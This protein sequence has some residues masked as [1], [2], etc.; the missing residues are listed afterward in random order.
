MFA[1]SWTSG[2]FCFISPWYLNA[3]GSYVGYR[4]LRTYK[5]TRFGR[6]ADTFHKGYASD[7]FVSPLRFPNEAILWC[8]VVVSLPDV[9]DLCRAEPR[10]YTLSL[11]RIKSFVFA[12]LASPRREFSARLDSTW[13]R[14]TN[15]YYQLSSPPE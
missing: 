2:N 11:R 6:Y 12:R 4:T 9:I 10:W 1:S 14:V 13:L 8:D 7:K 15:V 3:E 5:L